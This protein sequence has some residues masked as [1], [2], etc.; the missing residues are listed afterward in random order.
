MSDEINKEEETTADES[1][2]EKVDVT[3]DEKV[4]VTNDEKVDVTNND[5]DTADAEESKGDNDDDDEIVA[6]DEVDLE[7]EGDVY[8]PDA[9]AEAEP[10]FALMELGTDGETTGSV[11][12]FGGRIMLFKDSGVADKLAESV[13][14]DETPFALRGVTQDHLQALKNLASQKQIPL[15][16][17]T[18]ITEE[19]KVEAFPIAEVEPPSLPP[20]LG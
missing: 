19:G 4:D 20:T 11:W 9:N 13:S 12:S 8:K 18:E 15:F 14:S 5:D 2:D 7:V 6:G 3:T 17:I 1:T 16:V 10:F